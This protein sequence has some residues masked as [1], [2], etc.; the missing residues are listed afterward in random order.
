MFSSPPSLSAAM[1]ARAEPTLIRIRVS[2]GMRRESVSSGKRGVLEVGVKEPAEENRAN[3]R[4]LLL[5]AAYLKVPPKAVRI[6]RGHHL[7]VKLLEVY[8]NKS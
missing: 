7:R 1:T 6:V 4:A 8:A 2:P 5:V 3:A